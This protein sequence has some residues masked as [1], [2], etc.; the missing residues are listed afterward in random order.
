MRHRLQFHVVGGISCPVNITRSRIFENEIVKLFCLILTNLQL[1][2]II[3]D[4]LPRILL[5]FVL[6][7]GWMVVNDPIE[8]Q[9]WSENVRF[10]FWG[11]N[12]FLLEL[13]DDFSF[14]V[15]EESEM[16]IFSL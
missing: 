16:E 9:I 5:S 15:S 2:I 13:V 1:L 14:L 12:V 3:T 4:C 7:K 6:F 10:N 8:I 11:F